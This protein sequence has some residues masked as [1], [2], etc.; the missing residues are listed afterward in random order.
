M[1]GQS[2]ERERVTF[3]TRHTVK[4]KQITH[5]RKLK[6]WPTW[7]PLKQQEVNPRF[8]EVLLCSFM[9]IKR[10]CPIWKKTQRAMSLIKGKI[11]LIRLKNIKFNA[12]LKQNLTI[13]CIKWNKKKQ[14]NK[15]ALK[16]YFKTAKIL[17]TVLLSIAIAS[18]FFFFFALAIT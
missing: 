1:N 12:S 8:R 13:F 14:T 5:L 17:W 11:I 16:V 9:W 7:V 4:T 10:C 2:I 3:D 18:H 6:R 15:Q